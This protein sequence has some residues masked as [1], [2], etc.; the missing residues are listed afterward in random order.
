MRPTAAGSRASRR[1]HLHH[2]C[3]QGNYGFPAGDLRPLG[4]HRAAARCRPVARLAGASDRTVTWIQHAARAAPAPRR[5]CKAWPT[6]SATAVDAVA[7]A[8]RL[9]RHCLYA[10]MLFL[11][12]GI[13][14][15][16]HNHAHCRYGGAAG[17]TAPPT[18]TSRVLQGPPDLRVPSRPR[19][20]T[21]IVTGMGRTTWR[22]P[23]VSAATPT[24][25][26]AGSLHPLLAIT[27]C[28]IRCSLA[29]LGGVRRRAPGASR[30][31]MTQ[32]ARLAGIVGLGADDR[33]WQGVLAGD[34]AAA[35]RPALAAGLQLPA[36]C[37]RRRLQHR[38]AI[39]RNF[40]GMVNPLLFNI[41]LH[42]AHHQH[43]RAHWSELPRL[44]AGY[45]ERIDPR[46]LE[47]GFLGYVLTG[48]RPRQFSATL[49][50]TLVATSSRDPASGHSKGILMPTRFKRTWIQG[51][52]RFLPGPAIDNAAM[53]AYIAP[54]KRLSERIKRRILAENG[55]RAAP[56][57]D[58]RRRQHQLH[59]RR[60]RRR[61]HP[62][63]PGASGIAPGR[64]GCSPAARRAVTRL[65]PGFASMVQGELARTADADLRCTASALPACR[66]VES[67]AAAHR[68]RRA[69]ARAGR[70]ERRCRRACSSVRA[71]PRAATRRISTAHF[72]RWMLS[73]GAGALAADLGSPQAAM[74]CGLR[75]RFDPPA[76]VLGRLSGVHATGPDG[77]PLALASRLRFLG[78][79]EAD[80]ALSL[81]QDIRHAAAPVRHRH[82]RVRQAGPRRL[83]RSGAHRSFPLPLL[84][85]DV[86]R[87]ST[88]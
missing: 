61:G 16:H 1:H 44:H 88:N 33:P 28:C 41:G 47:P 23:G 22:A 25:C 15:I 70:G 3:Y 35:V 75:L 37:A 13:G 10:L 6:G 74:A 8:P 30:W 21:I 51:S 53:D 5:D 14:V 60:D 43:P 27:A 17:S 64:I 73:D 55:I 42:T 18:C 48:I 56:L 59:Q 11:A 7:M 2:A 29:W 69:P 52:G 86:R 12:M 19:G 71:T 65:M 79:G 78:G 85:G 34:R 40:E 45:R 36:T 31:Y 54:L 39:A 76:C 49:S 32:Y 87:W 77:R 67:A 4:R 68:T 57:R 58:R 72:L 80:G 50:L 81:R 9:Q 24:T 38:W 46:M 62:R 83:G 20:A 82:A 66:R 26:S 84:V 63:L